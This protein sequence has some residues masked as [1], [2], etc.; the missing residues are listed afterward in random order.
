M[1]CVIILLLTR[2]MF[3][4]PL[5]LLLFDLGVTAVKMLTFSV[6]RVWAL[7]LSCLWTLVVYDPLPWLVETFVILLAVLRELLG[8]QLDMTDLNLQT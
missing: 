7:A 3:S 4:E 8:A 6:C 1:A 5:V 2:L